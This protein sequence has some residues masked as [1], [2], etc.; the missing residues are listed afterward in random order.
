MKKAQRKFRI[1]LSIVYL[2]AGLA[3]TIAAA[4]GFADSADGPEGRRPLGIILDS[5]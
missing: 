2:L 1:T 4:A 5:V 3:L